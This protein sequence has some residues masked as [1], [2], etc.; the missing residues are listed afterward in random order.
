MNVFPQ[1]ARVRHRRV[2]FASLALV[3]VAA[4]LQSPL[5]CAA[6]PI[7]IGARG[8][9]FSYSPQTARVRHRRVGFASLAL[10]L[11]AAHL[12]SPLLCAAAPIEIDV[13]VVGS[14]GLSSA[15]PLYTVNR[16]PLLR[17]PSLKVPIR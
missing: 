12:Q 2:G 6:A 4:H 13:K 16:E 10:V 15:D 1:T 8:S 7:E 5:L 17:S 11:V 3:L 9:G 14:P